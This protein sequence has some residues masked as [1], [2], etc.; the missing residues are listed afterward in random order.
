MELV[1]RMRRYMKKNKRPYHV[2]YV[3]DPLCWTE[4]PDL[5]NYLEGKETDGQEVP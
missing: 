2:A 5:G 4:V 1:V 3:P